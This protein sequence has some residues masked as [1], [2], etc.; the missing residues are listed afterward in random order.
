[1]VPGPG[2][3]GGEDV[4]EEAL[5]SYQAQRE[6][7][8]SEIASLAGAFEVSTTVDH[9]LIDRVTHSLPQPSPRKRR[10]DARD[11][12]PHDPNVNGGEPGDI[13]PNTKS[14]GSS[15][16]HARRVAQREARDAAI[17]AGDP[18]PKRKYNRKPRKGKDKPIGAALDDE[19]LGLAEGE[20]ASQSIA[21]RSSMSP[22][23]Y[24]D[25]ELG[26]TNQP[27]LPDEPIDLS[28]DAIM[29]CGLTR[30]EVISKVA[31]NDISGLSE[32]D[33]KMVQDEIWA[34]KKDLAGVGAPTRKDGSMRKKPGPAKGWKK[35]RGDPTGRA[36][37]ARGD[38][39]SDAGDTSIAGDAVNGEAEVEIAALLPEDSTIRK[40][41][42]GGKRRKMDIADDEMSRLGE[43]SDEEKPHLTADDLASSLIDE[44]DST[45]KGKSKSKLVPGGGGKARNARPTRE[46]KEM[47]KK[48]EVVAANLLQQHQQ[49][50]QYD[51][52]EL[53]YP[54]PNTPALDPTAMNPDVLAAMAQS[55][56]EDM[57]GVSEMEAKVRAGLVDELQKQAW[58]SIVRDIPRVSRVWHW[59]VK[60][61]LTSNR[62]TGS[63]KRT[64]VLS[65]KIA[66]ERLRRLI[67]MR[68]H[69]GI[70]NPHS[71]LS[72][73][74]TRM[75]QIKPSGSSRRWVFL[76]ADLGVCLILY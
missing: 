33:V 64:I 68:L 52:Y 55:N 5:R 8:A 61:A 65:S 9:H 56:L 20:D 46:S 14:K 12:G 70:S 45:R 18:P 47:L 17:A 31:A 4:W 1:M 11:V 36:G 37:S 67:V 21:P 74:S 34:R 35:L 44:P 24:G 60:L 7:E 30:A 15:S 42:G 29:P 40:G 59:T 28:P 73:G 13:K 71:G 63:I 19:L 22:G 50:Q 39:D 62:C 58:A 76:T 54:K 66:R 49:Q 48:A 10:V 16:D 27:D 75:P 53:G 26:D 72:R 2:L 41:K 51:E 43:D 6:K 32:V 25:S 23:L 3:I 38:N 69:N 57:R